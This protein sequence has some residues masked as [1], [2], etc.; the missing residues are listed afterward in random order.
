[1]WIPKDELGVAEDEI[2]HTREAYNSIGISCDGASL[3]AQGKLILGGHPP[4]W[5]L[6]AITAGIM[7]IETTATIL[8]ETLERVTRNVV[9]A[10]TAIIERS[11]T[12]LSLSAMRSSAIRLSSVNN[13]SECHEEPSITTI[14]C[15]QRVN[16]SKI[17]H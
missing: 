15:Q 14:L 16:A 12:I 7:I 13:A 3:S 2:V 1:L 11:V 17:N 8:Q 6:K 10:D 9:I 4:D 5:R